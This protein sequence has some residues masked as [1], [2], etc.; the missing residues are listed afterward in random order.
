MRFASTTANDTLILYGGDTG[1]ERVVIGTGTATSAVTTGTTALNVDA[2]QVLNGLSIT[3]NA[4]DNELRGTSFNDVLTGGVGH[5]HL[6][7]GNGSDIYMMNSAAEHPEAEITDTGTTGSDEVR[8][9]STTT[10][11]TLILYAG[12]TGIERVVIGTGTAASAVTTG[13]TAL[14]VDASLVLNGLSIIGNAGANVLTGGV[15]IDSLDGG[16]GSDIYMMNS[17]VEHSAAEIGDTGTT[18]R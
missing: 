12:D 15:G 9:A 2:S 16:N 3:G 14:N 8:F 11:N 6:D 7:G 18:G 1:I 17:G 4:G 13:T 5:D 10:N